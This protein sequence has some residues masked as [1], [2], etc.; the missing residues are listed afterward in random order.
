MDSKYLTLLLVFFSLYVEKA[1]FVKREL[2]ESKKD[3]IGYV[4]TENPTSSSEPVE[5]V[6]ARHR[7]VA[8]AARAAQVCRRN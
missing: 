5:E 4:M 2:G 1:T 7:R 8:R 3:G 6:K